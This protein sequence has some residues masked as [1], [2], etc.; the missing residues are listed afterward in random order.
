MQ[1]LWSD[2]PIVKFLSITGDRLT[3]TAQQILGDG[4]ELCGGQLEIRGRNLK[5]E[6]AK[7]L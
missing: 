2:V 5:R 6:A 1:L 4:G 7:M 3:P